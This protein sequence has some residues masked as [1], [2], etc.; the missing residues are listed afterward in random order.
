MKR[1]RNGNDETNLTRANNATKDERLSLDWR[2][3]S[4]IRSDLFSISVGF[5]SLKGKGIKP[6]LINK[7]ASHYIED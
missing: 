7:L 1:L 4:S 3:E 6:L 5:G 2:G